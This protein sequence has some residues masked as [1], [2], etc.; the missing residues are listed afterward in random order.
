M[1][2]HTPTV[3]SF[4]IRSPPTTIPKI[5][6]LIERWRETS[7]SI[8]IRSRRLSARFSPSPGADG[9]PSSGEG[10]ATTSGASPGSRD[11]SDAG[12][13]LIKGDMAEPAR[14]DDLLTIYHDVG[15]GARRQ[16]IH[17]VLFQRL[18]RPQRG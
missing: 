12:L 15:N 7:S 8:S 13:D 5:V 18:D 11:V 9:W 1:P 16:R 17:H 3:P 4:Q 10:S 2:P 6:Q 14:G